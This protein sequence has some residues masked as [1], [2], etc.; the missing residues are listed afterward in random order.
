M[1]KIILLLFL[2]FAFA[3]VN[4]QNVSGV[5]ADNGNVNIVEGTTDATAAAIRVSGNHTIEAW[6]KAPDTERGYVM[7][8]GTSNSFRGAYRIESKSISGFPSKKAIVAYVPAVSGTD[9]FNVTTTSDVFDG[10]W[11][12]IAVVG[13]TTAGTTSTKI[14]VDGILDATAVPNYTRPTTWTNTA[15]SGGTMAYSTVGGRGTNTTTDVYFNG[16]IDEARFWTVARTQA[17]IQNESCVIVDATGL[18]RNIKLDNNIL[19][20][21]VNAKATAATGAGV[22]SY[23]TANCAPIWDG[24]S[25][26]SWTEASNWRL[27][28]LPNQNSDVSIAT[29]AAQPIID[30]DV[31]IK[32]LTL[33]AS[34]SLTVNSG[35][36]LT[37][38]GA[39]ANSGTMTLENNANLIQGGTTNTNTGNITVNRNSNP[40]LRLDYTMWSS[41]VSGAQTLADFSPLTSQSPNRFYSYDP[42]TDKYVEAAFGSPFAS[43][44]GY[45]IRMPNDASAVTPTAFAGVFTGVP[46]NG[47]I[48]LGSVIPLVAGQFY[49]VGN[50]YPSPISASSFFT[51]NTNLGTTLYFWRKTNAVVNGAPGNG[52]A[53]ATWTNLGGTSSSGNVAPNNLVPNGEIAVGQGFIV[54]TG[55]ATTINFTN[56]MRTTTAATFLKTKAA[57]TTDRVWLNLTNATGAFSQTLIGY[58]ANATLGIDNGIDG[59]YINDSPLAL[60]SNINNK[61]YTI[62]GRPSFD[63]TD[64][65]SLMFKTVAAGDYTIAIDHVDGVFATGQD[66][67]LIDTKTGTETNLK[68]GSYTF[69]AAAGVDNTRFS[70]KYQKTLAIDTQSFDDNSITVYATNGTLYVDSRSVALNNVTVFDVQGRVIAQKVNVK[71]TTAVINNLRASN[72][73]LIVKIEGENNSVFTKKLLN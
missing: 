57:A 68:T 33:N 67:Y 30:S 71:S 69:T 49:S 35:K 15:G 53:Y 44:T 55:T 58:T 14:Y 7:A 63:A 47:T 40:L 64:V 56:T 29:A 66:V 54:N 46:N 37:V 52:T 9:F 61:E 43:G 50:P 5:F 20:S 60:T 4:A 70:L 6:V 16:E 36:N 10:T 1:K 73:I 39:I 42:T 21:S 51:G 22:S 28:A 31:S 72:Q 2:F 12:H 65:V 38:T 8:M 62:Q 13:T 45:L 24:S 26:S 3:F 34:T 25:S 11:H 27:N 17:Q 18:Y 41:P 32:S 48:T 19:D 23:G 59:E